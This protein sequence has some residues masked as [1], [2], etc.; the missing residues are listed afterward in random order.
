M[1]KLLLI[2]CVFLLMFNCNKPIEKPKNLI[3]EDKMA[4]IFSDLYLYQQSHFINYYQNNAIQINEV[5]AE[6]LKNHGISVADFK[7]N[8]NYYVIQPDKYKNIL[9][10]VREGFEQ[11]LPEQEREDLIKE[12]NQQAAN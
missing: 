8:F 6:I 1:K 9:I 10:R 11:Q 3:S 5:D 12:R 4:E 2:S 7:E